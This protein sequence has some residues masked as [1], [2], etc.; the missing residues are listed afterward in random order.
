MRK[1]LLMLALLYAALLPSVLKAQELA[2]TPDHVYQSNIKSVKLNQAGDPLSLPMITLGSSEQLELA[3][4]D[5]DNDVKSYYYTFVLCNADWSPAQVNQL[6]Y[7]RGFSEIRIQNYKMSSIAF[8]RY[9][10]Y[11][12]QLPGGNS[13]PIKSGNYLLKV[14]LDSDTTQLAFT[15]R[16]MV[17][18]NKAG[19]AGYI[20]QPVS[21]KLF[22]THQKVNFE[23]NMGA[24][25]IPNPFDQIKVVI[26]QNG[27]WDNAVVNPRPQFINNNV[28]KYNTEVDCVIPGGKEFRWIDLR[29]FRLQTERVK[30]TEYHTNSTDVYAQPDV[31]RADKIYQ[32]IK[33]I[34]GKYYLATLDDYDP[35]FEGDYA[36]V[37][38]NFS[39][40][41][42]YAGYDMY[43]FGEFTNYETN[44]LNRMKYNPQTRAYECTLLLK[45]GYYNYIYGL[46][47]QRDPAGKFSTALT[48]GDY[49]ETENNYTILLYYRS[50]GTRID[51]LVST[52]T[53]NTILNRK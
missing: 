3:F 2:I 33:D 21:P 5:M 22:R 18:D 47:D 42:P 24:L 39:S 12:A 8:Q 37:H 49:W 23:V 38:F 32:F 13:F 31:E 53:L 43:I 27:R 51:Q 46:I 11:S 15:R 40:P 29:S 25:N 7:L 28:I 50:L 44:D 45:Q 6:E 26:L 48:E 52:I 35:N 9:T 20:Q 1:A 19:I 4:D 16:M 17:V 10:H 14:Y 34:N 36:S 30:H 41:E